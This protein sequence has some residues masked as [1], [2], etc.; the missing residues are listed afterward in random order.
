[1]EKYDLHELVWEDLL[2]K[3]TQDKIDVYDHCLFIVL[4]FPKY[5]QTHERYYANEFNIIV[6][7]NYAVTLSRYISNHIQSL[8]DNYPDVIN[9]LDED[10]YYKTS[11]YYILYRT[12]DTMYDKVLRWITRFSSDLGEIEEEIFDNNTM[13][14]ELLSRIVQKRRNI[15]RLKH[16]I[17]PHQ[18]IIDLIQEE[19]TKFYGYEMDV[20]FEDLAYKIDKIVWQINIQ[21][22]DIDSLYDTYNAMVSIKT[23]SNIAILTFFTVILWV[24][25]TVT[26]FYGMNITLPYA[27][28]AYMYIYLVLWMIVL[29]WIMAI[30]FNYKW[31]MQ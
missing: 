30:F 18:E 20:Y 8:K 1:M 29:W 6:W 21:V 12:L 10:E 7:K 16:M 23:T 3:I 4:H 27:Q 15:I 22:E 14:K 24:M 19:T 2:E 13:T 17:I 25:T 11:P 9:N 28:E 31:W 26:S 5:N